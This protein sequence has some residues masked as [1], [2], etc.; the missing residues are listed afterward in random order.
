MATSYL[1]FGS[2]I[3]VGVTAAV[4]G[5]KFRLLKAWQATIAMALLPV[6]VQVFIVLV[7]GGDMTEAVCTGLLMSVGFGSGMYVFGRALEQQGDKQQ[8]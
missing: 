3:A 4:M 2:I 8:K 7:S 6:A 5:I 1:L